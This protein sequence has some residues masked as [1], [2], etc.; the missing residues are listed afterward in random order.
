MVLS[1]KCEPQVSQ[2]HIARE[3]R[4]RTGVALQA[5]VENIRDFVWKIYCWDLRTLNNAKPYFFLNDLPAM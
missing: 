5:T 1:E 4:W 2:T 3:G